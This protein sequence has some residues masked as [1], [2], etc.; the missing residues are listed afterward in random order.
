MEGN[1]RA[2]L[3]VV[4]SSTKILELTQMGGLSP[5]AALPQ[6]I[7]LLLYN[8]AL[9]DTEKRPYQK[10]PTSKSHHYQALV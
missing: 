8:V 1:L 3:D 7:C 9:N 2:S 6:V 10:Q 4:M 5:R